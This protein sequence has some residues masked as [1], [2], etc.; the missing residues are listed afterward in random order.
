MGFLNYYNPD[1]DK[2]QTKH[3]HVERICV[4]VS[5][6]VVVGILLVRPVHHRGRV[7]ALLLPVQAIN[8]LIGIKFELRQM[9]RI[10]SQRIAMVISYGRM[11]MLAVAFVSA[12]VYGV[13]WL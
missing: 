10:R 6:M 3:F 1:P 7:A 12:A 11:A 8:F 13:P 5:F 2:K 4:V 9:R